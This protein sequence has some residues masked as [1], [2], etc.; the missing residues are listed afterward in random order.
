MASYIL[1]R[2]LLTIPTIFGI[3]LI[4][5]IIVQFAP[6]GPVETITARLKGNDQGATSRFD[7]SQSA[8]ANAG[9]TSQ[10]RGAQ[11]LSEEHL[12]QIKKQFGFDKPPHERFL[13][14]IRNF[15]LFDFGK[16]F[17]SGQE[18]TTMLYNALPV[19][20]SLGLWLTLLTYLIA[21]PLGIRK[22]VKDGMR[23]DVWSSGILVIGYAIPSFVLGLILIV[24]L[25]GG[26]YINLFPLQGLASTSYSDL[27]VFIQNYY[28]EYAQKTTIEPWK[29]IAWYW[30][31]VDYVWHITLP[32]IALGVGT[33]TTMTFLTKNSFLD[34]IK[35]QYVITARAKGLT[36]TR[37]LYG[38]IFRNAMLLIIAG[39]PG[40]F[41]TAFISGSLLIEQ[42]F[43]LSGIGLMSWT[44]ISERD[45][46]V[47]FGS[48]YLFSLLGIFVHLL[49][50]ITYTIVDPRI[51]F[52]SREV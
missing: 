18:V 15:L 43:G 32:L 11:G 40:A 24:F 34:E 6:G 26:N 5:F 29:Y 21:I 17:F 22:A 42:I 48:L 25:A 23:F 30:K 1:K 12:N 14:M 3:M 28:P 50:D 16:S 9:K 31:V 2:L 46:P 13:L 35:K 51:D 8:I 27:P 20:I 37:I 49:A 45:Y 38:H 36:E 39:F 44:A 7:G 47:I 19:S 41:L 10:Y 4:S 52:E 33:F